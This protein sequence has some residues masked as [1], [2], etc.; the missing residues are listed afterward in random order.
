M[1]TVT[2]AHH[3]LIQGNR[4]G[5]LY[6]LVWTIIL[7]VIFTACQGIE[8]SVSSF[9]ISDGVF[10]S[11]FY[12][13]TG[14]TE[15]P[16]ELTTI[17]MSSAINCKLSPY[18]LTGFAD[19]ESSFVVKIGKDA[20]RKFN[21]RFIPVF[22][23]ELHERDFQL[24]KKIQEFFG[25]GILKKRVRNGK[26]SVIYTVQSLKSLNEVIIPHFKEYHLLTQKQIDFYLFTKIVELI[27]EKKHLTEDGIN[28][29]ISIR[30]S[31]NKGLSNTLKILFPNINQVERLLI[32]PQVIQSPLW[33]IGF[34][35]GEGCFYVKI[36]KGKQEGQSTLVFSVT[37]H[38][39]DL[40]LMNI[41]KD[42]LGCGIIEKISTR[43]NMTVL[44][45]YKLKD[46]LLKIIP[47]FE[48]YSLL[49]IKLLDFKDFCKI[50]HL[51]VNKEHLTEQGMVKISI[52][53]KGMNSKRI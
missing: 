31:M 23:I 43:P 10:G 39:R 44:V 21:L 47:F 35:D 49:G 11:C 52:I 48:K 34:I 18:W 37:Q 14:L 33:L 29:I 50:A 12:F 13:G 7:A 20:T 28:E 27:N 2:W 9:T 26:P 38:S 16:I 40:H 3:A 53:K 45:I 19:A 8:Y 6:G 24:L 30:S 22:T 15:A 51:M 5:A 17:I 4:S 36:K 42:Y 25:V 32:Y 1:V 41:I 46:I